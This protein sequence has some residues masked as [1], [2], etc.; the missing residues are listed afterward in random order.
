MT[1]YSK[2]LAQEIAGYTNEGLAITHRHYSNLQ[3]L[4]RLACEGDVVEEIGFALETINQLAK[5]RN[6]SL[7]VNV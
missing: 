1:K 2:I 7:T 3:A 5:A 4:A 6:F